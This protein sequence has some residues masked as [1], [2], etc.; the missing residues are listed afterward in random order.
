MKSAN[1]LERYQLELALERDLEALGL[2]LAGL[3]RVAKRRFDPTRPL[4]KR[5]ARWILAAAALGLWLG[6]RTPN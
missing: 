2:A 3:E 4:K 6:W 5:P 1:R